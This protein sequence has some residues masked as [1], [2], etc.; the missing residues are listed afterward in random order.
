MNR[1]VSIPQGV[2]LVLIMT[3]LPVTASAGSLN[4]IDGKALETLRA[5]GKPLVL[6]DVR[7]PDEFSA[8]HIRGAVNIPY[9]DAKGRIFKELAPSDRIVFICH[10]GPMGDE[11]GKLLAAKNYP[12]V[13]NLAG[14]MKKWRG[15]L[16]R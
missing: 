8:G 6:V 15:E 11:L 2:F 4:T 7:D 3:A 16:V 10:G 13:Y 9:D 5:D 14:G 12:D 1:L